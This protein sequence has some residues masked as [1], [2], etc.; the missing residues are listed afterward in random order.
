[1]AAGTLAFRQKFRGILGVLGIGIAPTTSALETAETTAIPTIKSGAGAPSAADANGSLYLR[2]DGTSTTTVYLRASSAWTAIATST[3]TD[4]GAGGRKMDTLT[5]STTGSGV[6]VVGAATGSNSFTERVNGTINHATNNFNGLSVTAA[7]IST[8]RTG[9]SID[10]VKVALTGLAGDTAA[11]TYNYFE[12]AAPTKAGGSAVWTFAKVAAGFTNLLDLSGVATGEARISLGTNLASTFALRDVTTSKSYL[13][14]VTST[15]SEAVTALQR[16]TTTDGVTAGTARIIG[17][18]VFSSVGVSG[19]VAAQ[20]ETIYA[21]NQY[22][23]PA[24]TL[25]AGT[26]IKVRAVGTIGTA[27]GTFEVRGRLG[28]V[29]GVLVFDTGTSITPSNGDRFH[30]D[31]LISTIDSGATGHVQAM[32]TWSIGTVATATMRH[33]ARASVAID[34]T[35]SQVLCLTQQLGTGAGSTTLDQLYVEVIG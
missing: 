19:A 18:K 9:G 8:A 23:I 7:A 6:T 20:A 21:T 3:T 29:A 17:G 26:V 13:D 32:A 4:D 31:V 24:N 5:E 15:G 16:L 30:V 10:G 34:T 28:G 22:T 11:A 12:G 27:N 14:I 33:D 35:A 1:M 25:K 2:N